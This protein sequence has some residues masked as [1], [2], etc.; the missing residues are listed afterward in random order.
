MKEAPMVSYQEL[1][2]C[3]KCHRVDS[4]TVYS[5]RANRVYA[6]CVCGRHMV[7]VKITKLRGIKAEK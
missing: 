7:R 6:K 3:D 5:I 1:E 4:F 2:V